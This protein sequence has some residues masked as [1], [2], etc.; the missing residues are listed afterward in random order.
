[1]S[2]DEYK[3]NLPELKHQHH[4]EMS[5]GQ[6]LRSFRPGLHLRN[7]DASH[8]GATLA[9]GQGPNGQRGDWRHT[10]SSVSSYIKWEVSQPWVA[11]LLDTVVPPSASWS[12]KAATVGAGGRGGLQRKNHVY[13]W[14]KTCT[15]HQNYLLEE[16]SLTSFCAEVMSQNS[17]PRFSSNCQGT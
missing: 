4:R 8:P 10:H 16:P 13:D 9:R 14:V 17:N 15:V 12:V 2:V 6:F 3:K 7:S 1:M 11:D 5:F